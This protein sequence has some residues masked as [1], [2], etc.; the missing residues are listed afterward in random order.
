[1]ASHSFGSVIHPDSLGD[2]I[3]AVNVALF[4]QISLAPAARNEA[5]EWIADRQGLPGSYAG[6]FAPTGYDYTFG[7]L[8]F[9]GEPIRSGAA[10][11]HVLSEEA[12]RA[13]YRLESISPEVE[14]SPA[15]RQALDRARYGI[16]RRLEQSE[17][18]GQWSGV[19]CCGTCSVAL[20]R[21]LLASGA[22]DDQRRLENGL[23]EL[24]R[25][26]DGEGRWKRFPF[27]YTLLALTEI[28]LPGVREE[29]AYAGAV[30]ERALRRLNKTDPQDRSEHDRRRRI[31]LER[32]LE[33]C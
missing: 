10:T 13:L 30:I 20:W 25:Y 22:P 5:A 29:A 11:G 24:R 12:C 31:V 7:A 16:F 19:Y 1:M 33:K 14:T 15:I 27:Y 17:I 9:T 18:K 32:I 6:M 21:H 3:D 26:R 8:T 23:A 4:D 2:T 28:D